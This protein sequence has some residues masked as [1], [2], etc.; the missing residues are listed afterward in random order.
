M[1]IAFE[2]SLAVCLRERVAAGEHLVEENARRKNVTTLVGTL[3]AKHLRWKVGWCPAH[4]RGG[5]AG[6]FGVQ[7]NR[8]TEVRDLRLSACC[9][10]NVAW[11]HVPVGDGEAMGGRESGGDLVC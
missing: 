5:G 9:Q 4:G 3:T 6:R 11:L 2:E 10:H 8:E 7:D 1:R